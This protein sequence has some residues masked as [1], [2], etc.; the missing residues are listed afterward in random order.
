MFVREE[1]ILIFLCMYLYILI[2]FLFYFTF[3][4]VRTNCTLMS[5]ITLQLRNVAIFVIAD[6]QK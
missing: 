3:K 4:K 1:L 5:Y 2:L 6:V